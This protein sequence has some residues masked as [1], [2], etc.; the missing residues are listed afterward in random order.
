MT[1]PKP[2]PLLDPSH[3][4]LSADRPLFVDNRDGNTL[5]LAICRHLQSM[6]RE[7]RMLWT[8]K[9]WTMINCRVRR[10]PFRLPH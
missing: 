8:M 1:K 7:R 2:T 3:P 9:R 4:A 6:R 5:D 10:L